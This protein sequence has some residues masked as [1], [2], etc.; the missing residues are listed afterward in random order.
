MGI[1]VLQSRCNLMKSY[2]EPTR[3]RYI[4]RI[5]ELSG[6][7]YREFYEHAVESILA[8]AYECFFELNV[9]GNIFRECTERIFIP[10][11]P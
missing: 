6:S 9:N 2:F 10:K 7:F 4:S 8:D 11:S 1:F 3:D 5:N